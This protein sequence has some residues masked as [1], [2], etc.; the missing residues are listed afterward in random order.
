MISLAGRLRNEGWTAGFLTRPQEAFE[1]TLKQRRQALEQVIEQGQDRGLLVVVDYAEARQ[2]DVRL[3]AGLVSR[4][5]DSESRPVRV[6]LLARS[7][8]DWWMSL[9]DE[10]ADIQ[11]LFRRPGAA[12][13]ITELPTV[14]RPEDRREL[15]EASLM[16]FGPRLEAQ[17]IPRPAGT[18]SLDL[19][20]RIEKGA[21][22]SRPLAIQMAA[23]VWLASAGPP[24]GASEVEELLRLVLG[25]ERNHWRK[26][27]GDLD[28]ER[29]RDLTRGV[30]QVTAVQGTSTAESTERL[31]MADEFY[32]GRRTARADVDRVS[33]DLARVYGRIN[34]GVIPLEP[35][36]IGEHHVALVGDVELIE[37]CLLWVRVEPQELQA[38]R[39]RDV[40]TVLQR[41]TQPEHGTEVT[42]RAT[43]LL[44]HLI[45][46]HAATLAAAVVAVMV[47]TQEALVDVV[48]RRV[49]ALATE[50]LG[51]LDDALPP[52]SLSL[53]AVSMKI[54]NRRADLARDALLPAND[55]REVDTDSVNSQLGAR[56]GTLGSRLSNLG[57]REEALAANQEAVT[58]Y[59]RLAEAHADAFLPD[60]ATSLTN[61]GGALSNLG[62][63]EEA[64]A[65][66]EEAVSIY[67]RLAEARPDTFL[68]DLATSLNNLAVDQSYV[69]RREE[70]LATSQRAVAIRRR[71]V[72]ASPDTFLPDLATSLNNLGSQLSKLG[73]REGALAASQEAVAIRRHL[74][75]ARPDAFVPALATSLDNLASRLSNLGR[76]KE[77]LATSQEAVDIY[78]RLTQTH[79][80][81]FVPALANSLNNLGDDFSNL[82]RRDE[83]LATS[84]EA[85]E[86]YR[87]LSESYP[88]TFAP[89]LATSL[90]NQ[91]IWLSNLGRR[92]DAL[93]ASQEAVEIYR[94][95]ATASP[96]VFASE[97][98]T[99]LINLGSRLSDMGRREEALT[100]SQE[101]VE[102]YRR[103]AVES[104]D[105]FV[106]DLA[107]SLNSVAR[108]WSGVGRR[109]QALAA[110]QEA[111][112]IY[113]RLAEAHP[114]A[115]LPALATALNNFSEDLSILAR[116]RDPFQQRQRASLL[117]C[118]C[119]RGHKCGAV[120]V[121]ARATLIP[122]DGAEILQEGLEAVHRGAVG[123][124][125]RRGFLGGGRRAGRGCHRIASRLRLLILIGKHQRSPRLAHVPLDVI[126]QHA[127]E[128]MAA[129]AGFEMM[130]N[131]AHVEVQ[132]LQ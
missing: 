122:D 44:D 97:L 126:G 85:V 128:N 118:R 37:G 112:A 7:A 10:S 96:N 62:R 75:E 5:T 81:A 79:P 86:I 17:G 74:A 87:R 107:A 84:Q 114:D 130:V 95:L 58:I 71:L 117:R 52:Q 36:L 78:R 26:L 22:Y 3:L 67:Q 99:S 98:A 109:E 1:V 15:F 42:T 93:A 55:G 46:A 49:S 76:R 31:L 83:A 125:M 124:L 57:R 77:A 80:D 41:A 27:L 25:L 82:G 69:G 24:G 56:L 34:G 48:D 14:S 60:L 66:S 110:S 115:F 102:I 127:E 32:R 132:R 113:R 8:G 70:T 2:D 94:R 65:A 19:L 88:D 111:V 129:H 23:L 50:A 29:R 68:P 103:L 35:D 90:N 108:N 6:V 28:E 59:R 9:H 123:E 72:E 13:V 101:A 121:P 4:R 105:A 104:P 53:L 91:G 89:T 21:G 63:R 61:W 30:A 38:Q 100:S 20:A 16:A 18:P 51:A 45:G 40:I 47:D 120:V 33:R 12:H 131:R 92:K 39:R 43:V 73:H 116:I 11:R 106:P 54:A 64:V 119:G